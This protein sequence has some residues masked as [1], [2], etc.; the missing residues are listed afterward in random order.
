[1]GRYP[2]PGGKFLPPKSSVG[3]ERGHLHCYYT[4]LDAVARGERPTENTVRDGA[5]LQG[6]MDDCLRSERLGRWVEVGEA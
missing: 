1:M 6:L 2:A 3:W 4:F 5:R